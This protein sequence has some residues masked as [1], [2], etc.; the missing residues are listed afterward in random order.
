MTL[1]QNP[2]S[3]S[4]KFRDFPTPSYTLAREIPTLLYT[5]GLKKVPLSG[6]APPCIGHYRECPSPW[7]VFP[8]CVTHIFS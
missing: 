5:Q 4:S 7:D 3:G 2:Q 8:L 1:V 6:E